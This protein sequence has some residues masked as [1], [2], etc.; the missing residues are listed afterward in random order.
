M[1]I[2]ISAET[3]GQRRASRSA[4]IM[5]LVAS[6]VERDGG[7]PVG[8]GA[9]AAMCVCVRTHTPHHRPTAQQVSSSF[10]L[11]TELSID[12]NATFT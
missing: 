11:H 7:R 8:G 3:R 4:S 12:S 5:R 1:T 6:G 9:S 2:L 10:L